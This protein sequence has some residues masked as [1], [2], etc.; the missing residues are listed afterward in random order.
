MRLRDHLDLAEAQLSAG[1]HA[2][3]ARRDSETLLLHLTGKDRA[4]LIAH[5]DDDFGGCTA[6][7][8]AGL[9]DRRAKGEPIQYI[10]GECEFY[11]LPFRVTPDVLIPR[12][13]T[14]HLV[15]KVGEFAPR[16]RAPRI[17]DVGTGSGC[18]AISIAHDWGDADITAVDISDRALEIARGNAKR[19]GFAEHIRFLQGDL[20]APVAGKRFEIIVSNPPYVPN[21]DR[22]LI[23]VEV[24]EYE[25]A[26][27][28]FAG[29]DSVDGLDIYRR[30]IPAAFDALVPGGFIALEIGFT[31]AD[32]VRALL[33]A[34]GFTAIETTPDLQ[35]IPRVLTAQRP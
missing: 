34:R 10:T 15:E 3:R 32:S 25:P 6:V 7:H 20:L 9:V 23:A 26:V 1:P 18:I 17:L 33:S 8:Y 14:E 31:Q 22:A 19:I 4:W 27:A 21:T 30:L 28:L 2:D 35:G 16:F 13:E 12:P 29:A 24:R 11:G 5:R